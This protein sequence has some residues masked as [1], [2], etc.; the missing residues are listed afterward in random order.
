MAHTSRYLDYQQSIISSS[1]Q[2]FPVILRYG[3]LLSSRI[4]LCVVFL[5]IKFHTCFAIPFTC[6]FD[7]EMDF[8]SIY[9]DLPLDHRYR[10]LFLRAYLAGTEANQCVANLKL[11]EDQDKRVPFDDDPMILY[12]TIL[13]G[14]PKVAETYWFATAAANRYMY[15]T[16]T[17]RVTAVSSKCHPHLKLP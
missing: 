14:W 1:P 17:T 2:V 4:F 11:S 13:N 12:S 3:I 8:Y 5:L 9:T 6:F 16:P 7:E 10:A 15:I